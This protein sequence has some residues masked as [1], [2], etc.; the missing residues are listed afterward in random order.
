MDWLKRAK[1]QGRINGKVMYFSGLAISISAPVIGLSSNRDELGIAMALFIMGVVFASLG[2][3]F[4][5][6]GDSES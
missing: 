5:L 4:A 6:W 1:Q 2:R 3:W